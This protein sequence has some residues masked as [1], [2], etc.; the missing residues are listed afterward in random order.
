MKFAKTNVYRDGDVWCHATWI[1]EEFDCSDPLGIPDD[2]TEAEAMDAARAMLSGH[3][4]YRVDD[5]GKPPK[6]HEVNRIDD[7]GCSYDG[8]CE[9][10]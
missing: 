10:M 8:S 7:V 5:R 3:V 1:D 4:A 9:W 6:R 2:A